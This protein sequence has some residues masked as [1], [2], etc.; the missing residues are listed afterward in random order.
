M[1]TSTGF[2]WFEKVTPDMKRA[3]GFFGE[4]FGWTVRE[5]SG[6]AM[7]ANRGKPIGGYQPGVPPRWLPF[8]QIANLREAV[9]KVKSLGG[10]VDKQPFAV[11]DMG[12]EAV[13]TD[14]LGGVL[15]LWQP[16][17]GK[18]ASGDY[19]GVDG[20][21]VWSELY[22]ED[23]DRSLAFYEA[24][25]G[26]T[27]RTMPMPAGQPGPTRY[28]V[29]ESNGKGRAGITEF[30]ELPQMWLP[31]VQVADTDATVAKVKRLGGVDPMLPETIAGVGRLAVVK[32]PSGVGLG[33]LHPQP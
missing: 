23:V 21:W 8:L 15:A 13:V 11:R 20:S 18:E 25:G 3:Q 26:F 32:D 16:A 28:E 7:I 10:T 29:L 2:V 5:E 27:H 22:T 9:A 6:Y 4:L 33:L 30:P 1:A 12:T 19:D 14:P 17:P 31:Y 24:I